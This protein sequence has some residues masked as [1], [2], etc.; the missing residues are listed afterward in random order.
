MLSLI[1]VQDIPLFTCLKFNNLARLTKQSTNIIFI[2]EMRPFVE[3]PALGMFHSSSRPAARL[4]G[5]KLKGHMNPEHWRLVWGCIIRPHTPPCQSTFPV[6]D[7]KD[8]EDMDVFSQALLSSIYA[9]VICGCGLKGQCRHV[10]LGGFAQ[11]RK[12]CKY[13]SLK[14]QQQVSDSAKK[15]THLLRPHT[16]GR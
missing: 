3:K 1:Y 11:R 13:A 8:L 4:Q 5:S 9:P 12:L 7:M 6:Q 15:V 10:R 2:R 16:A 14:Q